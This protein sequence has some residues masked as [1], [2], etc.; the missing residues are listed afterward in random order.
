MGEISYGHNDCMYDFIIVAKSFNIID[1]HPKK[2][3]KQ[4][5]EKLEIFIKIN[6]GIAM[7]NIKMHKFERKLS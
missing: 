6:S 2:Y 4:Y 3:H 7:I 1:F 5:F